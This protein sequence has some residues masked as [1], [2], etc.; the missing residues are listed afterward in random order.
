MSQD[1]KREVSAQ[2]SAAEVAEFCAHIGIDF[3][4]TFA[5]SL[6]SAA[7]SH[8]PYAGYRWEI[9][10]S[11]RIKPG[12][13]HLVPPLVSAE[14]T[15]WEEWFFVDGQMHHHVLRNHSH[16]QATQT[17]QGKDDEHPAEVHNV[18]WHH[19]NDADLRP[20]AFQG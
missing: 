7:H 15:V 12:V 18:L 9:M 3:E 10:Q 14:P 4:S 16:A 8:N 20:S 17:W 13:L 1:W 19:F 2:W 11:S 6:A 5:D